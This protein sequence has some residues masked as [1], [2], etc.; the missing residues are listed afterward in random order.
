SLSLG[1]MSRGVTV[2]ENANAFATF[3]NNGKFVD[4]YMIDKI[5]TSD[6]KTIYQ[7]ESKEVD[8][9]SPQTNYLTLDIMRDVISEGTGTYLN[10]Q[11]KHSSFDWAGKTGTSQEWKDTWFVATNPNVTFATWMGY[12]TPKSLQCADCSLG[13]SD[14]NVK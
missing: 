1:G 2:E 3:G 10:S 9:F 4:A 6:G 5:E 8:V 14:R 7:H 11:L 13:Y 12:D